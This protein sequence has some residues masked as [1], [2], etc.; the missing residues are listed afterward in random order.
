[1]LKP[2]LPEVHG[3]RMSSDELNER[4]VIQLNA[5]IDERVD[6]SCQMRGVS[7]SLSMQ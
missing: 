6:V 5:D 2:Q 4:D 7:K 1:M 3:H